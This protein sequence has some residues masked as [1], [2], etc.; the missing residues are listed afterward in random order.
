MR[1]KK[2]IIE[3]IES[4]KIIIAKLCGA[5]DKAYPTIKKYLYENNELLTTASALKVIR[6]ELK[7]NDT[8][9]L[10]DAKHHTK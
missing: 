4:D 6:E 3:K 7:L 9:I 1:L 2:K 10:E 8:Q 5:M